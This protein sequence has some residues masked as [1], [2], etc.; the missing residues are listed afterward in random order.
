M[1][2]KK[3]AKP[4]ISQTNQFM[5]LMPRK[6]TRKEARTI[7]DEVMGSGIKDADLRFMLAIVKSIEVTNQNP[8]SK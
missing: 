8:S 3:G 4:D 7:T 6:L 5:G 1:E 2:N